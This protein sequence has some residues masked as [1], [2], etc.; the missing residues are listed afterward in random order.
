[1]VLTD[2]KDFIKKKSI[3]EQIKDILTQNG[4]KEVLE[5]EYGSKNYLNENLVHIG[6]SYDDVD[7]NEIAN[8]LGVN[9]PDYS[10]KFDNPYDFL[11]DEF[12][13]QVNPYA[14]CWL[15]SAENKKEELTEVEIPFFVSISNGLPPTT[16]K[17]FV[18]STCYEKHKSKWEK[19]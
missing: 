12:Q 16:K 11:K 1:M 4:F 2:I 19:K 6:L 13:K 8:M 3:H 9:L 14:E 10:I 5:G 18:C 17:H 15:C 7:E